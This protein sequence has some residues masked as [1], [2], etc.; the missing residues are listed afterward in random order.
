[1]IS[2][3]QQTETEEQNLQRL[4]ENLLKQLRAQFDHKSNILRADFV[5]LQRQEVEMKQVSEFIK[6][7]IKPA[8]MITSI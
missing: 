2:L 8:D 5:E 1:M 3:K 4:F 7:E 6:L